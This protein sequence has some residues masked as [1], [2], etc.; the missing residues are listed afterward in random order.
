MY[1]E[2]FFLFNPLCPC[3]ASLTVNRRLYELNF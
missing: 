1:S 2:G 3:S